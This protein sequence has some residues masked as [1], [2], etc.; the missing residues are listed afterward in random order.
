M[1]IVYRPAI[2]ADA[3][4][5]IALIEKC[6]KEYEGCVLDVD[7]EEPQLK[8]IASHYAEKGGEFW[9][10]LNGDEIVGSIGYSPAEDH[11]ELKHLYVNSSIRR[12]GI[13]STLCDFAENAAAGRK[14]SKIKLWTDTRFTQAH[15]LYE[16]RGYRGGVVTRDLQDLSKTS[17][18]YYE[19]AL[20]AV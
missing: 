16:R 5:L 8:A 14:M 4:E 17:E 1:E 20:P 15:S 13:A 7:A 6:Y 3:A 19:K 10:A 18:Y 2:D 9:V 12:Q 11:G